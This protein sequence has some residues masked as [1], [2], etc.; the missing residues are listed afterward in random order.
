MAGFAGLRALEV[1]DV[2][3]A[4]AG[5]EEPFGGLKRRGGVKGHFAEVAAREP[6]DAAAVEVDGREQDHSQ[7]PLVL[8][9]PAAGLKAWARA[10]P[11]PLKAA[12]AAW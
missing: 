7:S 8:G 3:V 5:V 6:H 2:D 10:M 4:A 11:T 9:S 1:H 12:S